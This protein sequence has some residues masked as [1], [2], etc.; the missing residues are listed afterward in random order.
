MPSLPP[1]SYEATAHRPSW[2]DLPPP[3]RA[4]I[5]RR[6]GGTV[7]VATSAG[8]GFTNGFA[9][10]VST[11]ERTEFVKAVSAVTHPTIANSYRTEALINAALPAGVPAPRLRWQ[12]EIGDWYALG[13]DPIAGRMPTLP[14]QPA[15]LAATLDAWAVAAGLLAVPTPALRALRLPRLDKI[16][17]SDLC[18]W[19]RVASGAVPPPVTG[20]GRLPGG[21]GAR[22]GLSG[23]AQAERGLPGGVFARV[24]LGELPLIESRLPAAVRADSVIHCDLRLDNVIIDTSGRAWLCD[25]NW[26]CHGAPW[27]DTA[28]LLITAYAAGLDADA[29]FFAHP[30]AQGAT[31]DDLDAALAGLSGYWL[32]RATQPPPDF[33]SPHLR[34]HQRCSGATA[35]TSLATRRPWH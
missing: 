3:V 28:S 31:G 29:L 22:V 9:A 18:W 23:G 19:G 13:F 5:E 35:L 2:V 1:V 20:P 26:P 8:G 33:G 6:V 17:Q 24:P 25:W 21:A 30:T 11:R 4:A 10:V 16:A 27:L 7:E 12:E 15:D 34:T 32:T 14:W